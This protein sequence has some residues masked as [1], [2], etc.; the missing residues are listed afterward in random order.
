MVDCFTDKAVIVRYSETD[1][2][3]YTPLEF[4]LPRI[5]LLSQG[6]LREFHEHET[7]SSTSI[8]GGIAAR[9]SRYSKSG[10]LNGGNY[11][12]AGTKCVHLVKVAG[13][14]RISA[15]AWVDDDAQG[16]S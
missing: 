2:A 4:A 6:S 15:L 5:E 14:W 16:K 3:I 7:S 11:S 9:T 1:T 8:F 10:M 13:G 12:G